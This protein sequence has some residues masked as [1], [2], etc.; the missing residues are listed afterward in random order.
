MADV[1]IFGIGQWAEIAH[2]YLV[3]DSPH[4]IV[5]FTVDSSYMQG[6]QYKGLPLV[7]FEQLEETFPP[8]RY[9][10]FIPISYKKMN[11]IRADKY[12]EAKQRGYE[13]ISYV[14]SK[15]TIWPG[16]RCGDNCFILEDNRIQPFVEIGSNVVMWSG[17]HVG[18]H[19]KVKDHVML[20]SNVMISGSCTIEEYCFLAGC[21][22]IR[23]DLVIARETFVGMG[24]AI[25]K[26]TKEYE[27]YRLRTAKPETIRSDQ[28]HGLFFK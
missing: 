19:S 12:Y 8:D 13:L 21:C 1:V 6:E 3:H 28:L 17:N 15:A 20:A 11:H 4:T 7:P 5:G 16:F 18:H 27:L 24:V 9:K 14:S 26:S 10:L 2:F 22:C 25:L 23:E